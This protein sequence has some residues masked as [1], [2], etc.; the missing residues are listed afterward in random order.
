MFLKILMRRLLHPSQSQTRHMRQFLSPIKQRSPKRWRWK[1]TAWFALKI[2]KFMKLMK[3]HIRINNVYYSHIFNKNRGLQP[4]F[5]PPS[6]PRFTVLGGFHVLICFG[7]VPCGKEGDIV[8]F[9]DH[10]P[11]ISAFFRGWT[12]NFLRCLK[13][14]QGGENTMDLTWFT[15]FRRGA[16]VAW[17]CRVV[18]GRFFLVA[19]LTPKNCATPNAGTPNLV[20]KE[21]FHPT[22]FQ[23]GTCQKDSKS[24]IE[25]DDATWTHQ[26]W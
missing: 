21:W 10:W 19:W 2:C 22:S 25:Y 15:V 12:A 20:R 14:M 4:W 1:K 9:S 8:N 24:W 18:I 6:I 7:N 17:C 13:S 16:D 11:G 3:K 23:R 5:T 26:R